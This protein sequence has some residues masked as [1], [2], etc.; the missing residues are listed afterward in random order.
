MQPLSPAV[1]RENKSYNTNSSS[2]GPLT[3]FR[4]YSH[5]VHVPCKL[6]VTPIWGYAQSS[7]HAAII[8]GQQ[9]FKGDVYSKKYSIGYFPLQIELP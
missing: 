8:R 3:V 2:A 9:P 4:D 6:A 5:H 1:S 7:D